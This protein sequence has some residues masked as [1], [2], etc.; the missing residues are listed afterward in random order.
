MRIQESPLHCMACKHEWIGELLVD[1]PLDVAVAAMTAVR[2]PNCGEGARSV[3]FGRGE[4]PDPAPAQSSGMTDA[5]RRAA[6][7]K[8]H[9]DGM[10]SLCIADKMSG[11][12][13]DGSYPHDA[14]DFGRCERLLTLY[15]EWR[16]RLD[17]MAS[18]NACWAALVARWDEIVEAYHADMELSRRTYGK[19]VK[20]GEWK[21]YDLMQSILEP[22]ERQET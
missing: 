13:P 1:V 12:T 14:Y 9:D 15:P 19:K 8:L 16:A 3:A 4:V 20:R 22:A 5:E 18:V 17:E 6:W 10:S 2:C 21:C 7:L 11:I